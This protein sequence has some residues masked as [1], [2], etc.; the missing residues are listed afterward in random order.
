ME[1]QFKGIWIPAHIW[2]H[3]ELSAVDKVLLADIDSFTG[4]GKDFYKSNETIASELFVSIKSVTRSVKRLRGLGLIEVSGRT[5]SRIIRSNM[6]Q[7]DLDSGQSDLNTG[8]NDQ[9][10]GPKSPTTNTL[11]KP[12]TNPDTKEQLPWSTDTFEFAWNEWLT[13]KKEKR[14]KYTPT[15]ERK[16]LSR[17]YKITEGNEALAIDA[18]NFSIAQNYQGIFLERKNEKRNPKSFD[19]GAYQD[20]IQTL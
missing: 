3:P 10:L 20:F 1:R 15:G 6:G 9:A 14:K 18:I 12:I 4:N 2:L 19:T 13:Y 17:L 11:S 8:Q 7:F 16:A 5:T